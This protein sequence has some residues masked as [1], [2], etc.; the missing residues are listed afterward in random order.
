MPADTIIHNAVIWTGE[1]AQPGAEA[2]AISGDKIIAVG[3]NKSIMAHAGESTETIDAAGRLLLP[4]FIDTHVHFLDGGFGL[5]SVRLRSAKTPQEFSERIRDFA[6][7]VPAGTWI[8]AGEWDHENWGG[9][10]PDRKW[11][12]RYT[13]D[14]P[15]FVSRLDGHM[16]LA[17]SA[18]LAFAGIDETVQDVDGGTIVR[19]ATGRLTGILKDNAMRLVFRKIPP[20]TAEQYDQALRAA[21]NYVAS[22]GVTTIHNMDLAGP[23][24][25]DVFERARDRGELI[26]RS[27]VAIKLSDW[28]ALADRV[29][30]NGNGDEYFRIG[31]LKGMIDGSLGSH[32]AAFFEPFSDA[33]QDTGLLLVSVDDLYQQASAADSAGLQLA[34]HGIGDRANNILLNIFQRIA[35]ENGPRDRRIRIEHAQHLD[36]A[37]LPRF[38]ALEIIASMQPYHA[39]DD[40]RWAEDVIGPERIKTTYAFRS[41]LDNGAR[42]AFGSDWYVAP[43]IPLEGIYAAV[44]RR[45]IDEANPEGWV[46]DQKITV[47]EALRAYT[48]EGAYS[49]FEEDLKGS[50]QPGKLADMVLLDQNILEID[51]VEIRNTKV[52]MT[53]VGGKTV[54][55][56]E[57]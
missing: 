8:L 54:Y 33:P 52:L 18:A 38:K 26:T 49:S 2:L 20:P 32:T 50:L 46:P 24:I 31:V 3:D 22:H 37:D 12:D 53:M 34:I 14:H 40:G 13:P 7:T 10:L 42:L 5:S 30:R 48:I 55:R 35:A 21:M 15:V 9:E 4:G 56:N 17:N 1:R 25:F 36:P 44:T 6:A 51:P 23:E 16:G 11:I 41:L 39:I 27:Y 57:K 28:E 45:T 43:P 47:E 19:D 29:N